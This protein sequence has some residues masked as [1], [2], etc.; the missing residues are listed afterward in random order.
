MTADTAPALAKIWDLRIFVHPRS[1]TV[2]DKIANH[3]ETFCLYELL[4]RCADVAE[5][6][7]RANHIDRGVKRGFGGVKE[8]TSLFVNLLAY[9]HRNC[10][11][12][13]KAIHDGSKVY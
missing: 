9:R 2:S 11:I 7:T 3:G 13:V 4:N 10:R 5:C 8:A 6:C 12:A 1:D